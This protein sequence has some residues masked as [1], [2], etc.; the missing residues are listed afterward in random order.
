M[1]AI[2]KLLKY[3]HY[4][5]FQSDWFNMTLIWK[6]MSSILATSSH[7]FLL[8]KS[9]LFDANYLR[10]LGD[11]LSPI[12][13]SKDVVLKCL[14]LYVDGLD[15]SFWLLISGRSKSFISI[16]CE[17]Y[18]LFNFDAIFVRDF[19]KGATYSNL[20][21]ELDGPYFSILLANLMFY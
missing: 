7:Y 12:C 15:L 3:Q 4:L 5:H 18:F 19:T 1:I 2:N 20:S 17:P 13:Y 9:F 10:V 14:I 16:I 21:K 6:I 11:I 8:L